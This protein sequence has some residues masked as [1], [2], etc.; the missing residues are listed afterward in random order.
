METVPAKKGGPAAC[1]KIGEIPKTKIKKFSNDATCWGIF[2]L[3][4]KGVLLLCE[5]QTVL[6]FLKFYHSSHNDKVDSASGPFWKS[7]P[8][9][10]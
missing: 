8:E 3:V 10:C 1:S 2:H 7:Y 4:W 9:K 5:L 6:T